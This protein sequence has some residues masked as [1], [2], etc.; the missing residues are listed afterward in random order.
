MRKE[1]GEN[2][3]VYGGMKKIFLLATSILSALIM[4]FILL[5]SVLN[6]YFL[7]ICLDKGFLTVYWQRR[8]VYEIKT[9]FNFKY[10]LWIPLLPLAT[11]FAALLALNR[12]INSKIVVHGVRIHHYH[13]G[14]LLITIA[15]VML[16]IMTK[17]S[18][19]IVIWLYTKKTSIMEILQG[20]SFI[21]ALAGAIFI[22]LDIKDVAS[23]LEMGKNSM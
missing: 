9:Q 13:I 5:N 16:T 22:L 14:L 12:Q 18:E 20:L 7:W 11:V 15:T 6:G 10:P 23:K 8:S 21:F 2:E 4:T 3:T 19:P 17:S 1:S